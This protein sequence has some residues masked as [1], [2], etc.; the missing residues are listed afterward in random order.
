MIQYPGWEK[1]IDEPGPDGNFVPPRSDIP[2]DNASGEPEVH[3]PLFASKLQAFSEEFDERCKERHELGA[4][5][6]GPGKFLT[7][8]TFEEA[9]QEIIDL[10]NYARYTYVRLRAVQTSLEEKFGV[11][12]DEDLSKEL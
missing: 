2:A 10:A 6:Y 3:T 11:D 5:K 7:V 9:I 4:E 1:D 8:D 12:L